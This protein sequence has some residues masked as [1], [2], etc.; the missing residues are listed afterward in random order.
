[1]KKVIVLAS[2]VCVSVAA[3]AVKPVAG[4]QLSAIVKAPKND[5]SIISNQR[6]SVQECHNECNEEYSACW[7]SGEDDRSCSIDSYECHMDCEYGN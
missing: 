5:S 6:Q 1:M 4:D 3:F 2:L 7:A